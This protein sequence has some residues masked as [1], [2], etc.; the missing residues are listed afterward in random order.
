MRARALSTVLGLALVAPAALTAQVGASHGRRTALEVHGGYGGDS[1]SHL[2]IGFAA[3]IPIRSA[4]QTRVH[5]TYGPGERSLTMVGLGLE[6]RAGA[7]I[8]RPYVGG[9][10]LW[11]HRRFANVI[12]PPDR[13]SAHTNS[14]L[15]GFAVVG[16]AIGGD[17]ESRR[18]AW[19]FETRGYAGGSTGLQLLTGLHFGLPAS[20]KP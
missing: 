10:P 15:G 14:G 8:V 5:A 13:P 1:G 12:V 17:G 18:L 11:I 20:G 9:G 4:L 7:G 3:T 2:L 16:V 6:L 19:L